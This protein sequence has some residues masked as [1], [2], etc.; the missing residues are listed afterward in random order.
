MV[1]A[2]YLK[3]PQVQDVS[4]NAV[5]ISKDFSILITRHQHEC[6]KYVTNINNNETLLFIQI[7]MAV[8]TYLKIPWVQD[9]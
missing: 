7:C 4:I 9:F 1:I 3:I 2:T 6:Q 8:A 5:R